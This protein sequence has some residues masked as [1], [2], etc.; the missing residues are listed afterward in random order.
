MRKVVG[1]GLCSMLLFFSCT[2]LGD[3]F[4]VLNTMPDTYT[5]MAL[6]NAGIDEYKETLL[7]NGDVSVIPKI[8][9]YFTTALRYDPANATAERYLA[10]VDDF[11]NSRLTAFMRSAAALQKKTTRTEDDEY[12]LQHAIVNA[13][14]LDSKNEDAR[15]LFASTKDSRKALIDKYMAKTAEYKVEL[16]K[17]PAEP[18]REKLLIDSFSLILKVRDIDP[19]NSEA[20]RLHSTLKADITKIVQKYLTGLEALYAKASFE[21][22]RTQIAMLRDLDSKIDKMF[23]PDIQKAEYTLYLRWAKHYQAQKDYAKAEEKVQRAISIQRGSEAVALQKSL[24]EAKD[25]AERGENFG[26]GLQNL[27]AYI[28]KKNLVSAQRL[29]LALMK[30]ATDPAQKKELEIRSQRMRES[31]GSMYAEAVRAYNEERFKDAIALLTNVITLDSTNEEAASY[32]EKA[33][34]KQKVL[35]Q[36]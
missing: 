20:T 10:L 7:K 18:K 1:I 3:S 13:L 36:Y 4:F 22:G 2:S 29:L 19:Q 24:A 31:L 30:T 28:A 27:D 23:A 9:K 32:L 14:L 5:S 15:A 12:A 17:L 16:D 11:Q 8:R 33:Q 6:T 25:K 21:T 34:A 26:A 35:D